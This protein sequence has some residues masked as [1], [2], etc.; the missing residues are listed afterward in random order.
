VRILVAH[1]P[2]V[3]VGSLDVQIDLD[4][5]G[6]TVQQVQAAT[7]SADPGMCCAITSW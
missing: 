3:E 6:G 4:P 2:V 7:G 5:D 1:E